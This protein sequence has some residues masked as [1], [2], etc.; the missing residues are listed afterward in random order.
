LDANPKLDLQRLSNM[1]MVMAAIAKCPVHV[2]G[3]Y[4]FH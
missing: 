1:T 4:L 2:G 3:G